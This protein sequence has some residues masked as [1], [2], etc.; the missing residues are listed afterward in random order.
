[1]SSI[2]VVDDDD[3]IVRLLDKALT[4][5]GHEVIKCNGGEEALE[6]AAQSQPDLII[7][8]VEMPKL[9]G[10]QVLWHLGENADTQHI[11]TLILSGRKTF[12]D[13]KFG[14]KL[15]ARDYIAKPFSIDVLLNRVEHLLSQ[16]VIPKAQTH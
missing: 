5:K 7:L 2:L 13:K 8:D 12:S 1:M 11:Q 16:S 10:Y 3:D 4:N 9:D 14:L 6:I 15:G